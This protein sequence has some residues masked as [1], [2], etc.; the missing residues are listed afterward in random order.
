MCKRFEQAIHCGRHTDKHMK[1]RSTL[2][3]RKMQKRTTV[4]Y[5]YIPIITGK[6]KEKEK[7]KYQALTKES[8]KDIHTLLVGRVQNVTVT[9]KKSLAISYKVNYTLT[10]QFNNPTPRCLSKKDKYLNSN[11]NLYVNI[12]SRFIHNCQKLE[13]AQMSPLVYG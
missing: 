6:L 5:Y 13:T 3:I 8:N 2:V 11:K 12:Y 9:S 4:R 10:I 7:R 1:R